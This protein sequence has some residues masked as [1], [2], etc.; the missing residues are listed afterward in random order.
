MQSTRN[1]TYK[2]GICK[3]LGRSR[4]CGQA[5][6][7]LVLALGL[8]LLA[9]VSFSVDLGNLWW[10]RQRAQNAA[11]AAC[12]A[13]AMDL[14]VDA[15]S[16]ATGHQGFVLGQAHNCS[17]GDAAVPCK[18]ASYNGYNSNTTNNLVSVSWPT[19]VPSVAASAIPAAAVV[20]NPFVRIDVLDHVPTY[21]IGLFSGR[22]TQDVRNVA[23]CGALNVSAPIPL[24]ILHPSKS[25]ALSMHGGGGATINI[26]IVGGPSKSIQVNSTS[27]TAFSVS[28][29]SA[30]VDLSQG[31]PNNTGSDFGTWGGPVTAP[32]AVNFGS[33]GKWMYQAAPIMDPFSNLAAPAQPAAAPTPVYGVKG[34]AT[35][36]CPDTTNGCDHYFPGYYSGGITI[37]K[38]KDVNGNNNLTA[39]GLAVFDPGLYYIAGGFTANS[40]SCLR[41]STVGPGIGGTVFYLSGTGTVSI[42][43]NSGKSGSG[44]P[45]S[46]ATPFSTTSGGAT[47][48]GLKCTS[49]STIPANLLTVGTLT[50]NVLLA[51][52]TGTYGDQLLSNT[53][54]VSS[55]LGEQRGI[56]FF[57]DRG[58]QNVSSS[59]GGGGS[60]IIAGTLYFHACKAGGTGIGC[61]YFSDALTLG[62]GSGSTTYTFGNIVTDSLTLGGNSGIVMDLNATSAYGILKATLLP[63]PN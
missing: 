19:S 2:T 40:G 56:L 48:L 31:G 37:K 60:Y 59:L 50:G 39:T 11:D 54:K 57:Q 17:L 55:T 53:G 28:G 27:T 63:Y 16:A 18:Y 46:T 23:V 14:L 38:G 26:G 7:F 47:G 15:Q 49:G 20:P 12:T 4:E 32:S 42:G 52:C 13:T 10:H 6:L 34:V 62:G 1:D 3:R 35:R 9:A 30:N 61:T 43:A 36:G 58:A 41:P 5:L 24:L 8:F 25:G 21:F 22:R 29:G 45:C 51:P 44:E 33:T